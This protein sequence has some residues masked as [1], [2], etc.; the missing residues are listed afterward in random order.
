MTDEFRAFWRQHFAEIPPIGF[1][2][3]EYLRERWVRFHSLPGSKR[4]ADNAA[5]RRTIL[6][7]ANTL[8]DE[9]F[10]AGEG[11]WLVASPAQMKN[12]AWDPWPLGTDW[13][14]DPVSRSDEPHVLDEEY[15]WCT[16][17]GRCVWQ[18]GHF[19]RLISRIAD[20]EVRAAILVSQRSG[21]VFAPYDGGVD[22]IMPTAEAAG[23]LGRKHREWRPDNSEG[24]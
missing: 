21:A 20:D 23:D 19:D 18:H 2:L 4:Y 8:A 13:H 14:L 12:S 6:A 9:I 15:E 11:C 3:R 16:Y 17:A 5:E 22:I 7:R 10:A 24:L 1:V